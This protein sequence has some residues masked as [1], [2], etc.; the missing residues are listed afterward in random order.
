MA[1]LPEEEH[2]GGVCGGGG[3]GVGVVYGEGERER[4]GRCCWWYCSRDAA[5]IKIYRR[6]NGY[7]SRRDM[8]ESRESTFSSPFHQRRGRQMSCR[9]SAGDAVQVGFLEPWVD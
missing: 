3:E 8:V 6:G 1:G 2:D 4:V 7:S 9:L 5:L